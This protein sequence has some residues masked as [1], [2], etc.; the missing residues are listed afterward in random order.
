M[1]HCK[2]CNVDVLSHHTSCPLCF[3]KLDN[4]ES[5]VYEYPRYLNKEKSRLMKLQRVSK[6]SFYLISLIAFIVNILT[7]KFIPHFWSLI[8]SVG[9]LYFDTLA[10][11]TL[12][13]KRRLGRRIINNYIVLALLFIM[14]DLYKGYSGWSFEF[15]LPL[16]SIGFSLLSLI[17]LLV[18]ERVYEDSI[19]YILA[20]LVFNI[21]PIIIFLILGLEVIWPSIASLVFSIV[22]ILMMIIFTRRQFELEIKKRIHF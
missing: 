6:Y 1:K 16:L 17:N 9:Y 5:T 12:N 19:T 21:V 8:V 3:Q 20:M 7:Y 11:D 2:E 13:S 10:F 15:A 14:I 4:Y 22:T 18:Y